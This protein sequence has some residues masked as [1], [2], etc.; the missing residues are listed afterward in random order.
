M[1]DRLPSWFEEAKERMRSERKFGIVIRIPPEA[2]DRHDLGHRIEKLVDSDTPALRE[3]LDRVVLCF[4]DSSL[5]DEHIA[6]SRAED[7]LIAIYADGDPFAGAPFP[8][9]E[10]EREEF[11]VRTLKELLSNNIV[12]T[13]YSQPDQDSGKRSLPFGIKFGRF[14]ACGD[15][16]L[17]QP[18]RAVVRCGMARAGRG[19]RAFIKFLRS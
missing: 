12:R 9:H 3:M 11:L 17:E 18:E 19:A 13:H 15:S 16:C 5:I 14:S 1:I 2:E 6:G 4:L 7:T 10:I 8:L